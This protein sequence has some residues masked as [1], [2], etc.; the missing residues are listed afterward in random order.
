MPGADQSL[1]AY[2]A[3][4][5]MGVRLLHLYIGACGVENSTEGRVAG[6]KRAC[7]SVSYSL[8]Y[9]VAWMLEVI[10]RPLG[11]KLPFSPVHDGVRHELLS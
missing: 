2:H 5:K 7:P 10:A 8:L 4:C 11:I 3:R 1:S 6:V 9:A